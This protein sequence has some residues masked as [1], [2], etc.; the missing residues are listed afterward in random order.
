MYFLA[1][2][3][4]LIQLEAVEATIT[5]ITQNNE[6]LCF[7][8]KSWTD[9][10]NVTRQPF[11][12]ISST[13]IN[14]LP[15]RPIALTSELDIASLAEAFVN[16]QL[17]GNEN[18]QFIVNMIDLNGMDVVPWLNAKLF[19]GNQSLKI[20]FENSQI[21]FYI[22]GTP[23][24]DLNCSQSLIPQATPTIFNIF[25]SVYYG[26]KNVYPHKP[27]C[28]FIFKNASL[29]GLTI[30]SHIDAILIRN[31]WTFQ[32][33]DT[34]S[35][36]L[37]SSI[38]SLKLIGYGYTLDTSLL[39]PLV[40]K[41]ID[42]LTIRNSIN[43]IQPGLF[44][45]FCYMSTVVI[46]VDNLGNFFHKIGIGW[47]QNL[48]LDTQPKVAFATSYTNLIEN[49]YSYPDVDFCLFAQYTHTKRRS[50]LFWTQRI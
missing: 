9:L 30:S 43:A 40:F 16:G 4:N 35:S 41:R 14:L 3:F 48:S 49:Q 36:I 42:C 24:S 19:M 21:E 5:C 12:A 29:F 13:T 45:H 34:N 6:D 17:L 2:I 22:N 31:L 23:M 33:I 44:A 10:N 47:T 27:I 32:A 11:Y 50:S 37:D 15:T 25:W 39:N 38:E 26:M 18:Q 7:Y 8:F 46:V 20:A 28:P 1:A